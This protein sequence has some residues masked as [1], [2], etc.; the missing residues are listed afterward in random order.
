MTV[1]GTLRIP[2]YLMNGKGSSGLGLAKNG[3][4]TSQPS[5]PGMLITTRSPWLPKWFS[6]ASTWQSYAAQNV[7]ASN[8]TAP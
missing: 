1:P 5:P 3:Q 2:C 4:S 7:A 6:T 8:S